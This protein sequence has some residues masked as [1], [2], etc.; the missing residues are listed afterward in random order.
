MLIFDGFP[1]HK[2]AQEFIEAVKEIFP[3][4]EGIICKSHE[5]SDQI[6]PFPFKLTPPIVLL[7]RDE[8]YHE[9]AM[10]ALAPWFGGRCAGT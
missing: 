3:N 1:N 6:D 5:E 9:V 4:Q 8:M 2:K 10:E 7:L